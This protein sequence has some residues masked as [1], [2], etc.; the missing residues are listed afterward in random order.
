MSKSSRNSGGQGSDSGTHQTNQSPP[1]HIELNSKHWVWHQV[2]PI[3]SSSHLHPAGDTW[4]QPSSSNQ[5]KDASVTHNESGSTHS[6]DTDG[7][8]NAPEDWLTAFD[9]FEHG[10]ICLEIQGEL[11]AEAV[12][13]VN[14]PAPSELV[15]F[16]PVPYPLLNQDRRKA[17]IWA[18]VRH[19]VRIVR[20]RLKYRRYDV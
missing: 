1:L 8:P 19:L 6:E 11:W 12:P 17:P 16:T 2:F 4:Q 10:A 20:W 3:L 13:T 15:C 14:N 5:K 18:L 7:P 9:S